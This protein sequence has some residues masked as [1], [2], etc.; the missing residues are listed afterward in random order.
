[1]RAIGLRKY[2]EDLIEEEIS[3][4][5][6]KE[7][8]LLVKINAISVN[9]IDTKI[10]RSQKPEEPTLR[11]LGFDACGI[12][13][14]AGNKTNLF[15]IGD[16]VFYSGSLLKQGTN[17]EYHIIDERLVGKASKTLKD[18]SIASFP[19]VSI[20][21]F[22]GLFERMKVSMEKSLNKEKSILIIGGAGGV[23]SIAI[24]LAKQFAG[25]KVIATASREKSISWCK[26][27]GADYVVNHNLD[28][29]E[30]INSLGLKGFDY[31]FCLNDTNKYFPLMEKLIK[32][33]GSI[34][35]IVEATLPLDMKQLRLKSVT[36]CQEFMFTRSMF[37][38]EDMQNQGDILNI[39]SKA[40]DDGTIIDINTTSLTPINLENLKQ[41]NAMIESGKVIG[42]ISLYD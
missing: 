39:I 4:P 40:I 33:Q 42:K 38:T 35:T 8:E 13:I 23:G 32:P 20:T 22:E 29:I 36:F 15:K 7:R 5:I 2:N 37:E 28:I 27:M 17:S 10:R 11:V 26:K 25:L 6:P 3:I 34:C 30:Q 24:Q 1:M 19:L 31:I 14:Q 21:A 18:S 41:A 9:P 16:K 12:V